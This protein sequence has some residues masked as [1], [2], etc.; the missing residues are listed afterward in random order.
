MTLTKKAGAFMNNNQKAAQKM[1]LQESEKK[2]HRFRTTTSRIETRTRKKQR[3]RVDTQTTTGN[4][5]HAMNVIHTNEII[6]L[7]THTR[8]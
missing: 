3:E 2:M 4:T 8:G 1:K 6:P 5:I 7:F